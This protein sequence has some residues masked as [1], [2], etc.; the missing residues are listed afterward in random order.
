MPASKTIPG[1]VERLSVRQLSS[2]EG[3]AAAVLP[4]ANNRHAAKKART[5]CMVSSVDQPL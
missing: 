3:A 5:G 4:A 2:Q 1:F